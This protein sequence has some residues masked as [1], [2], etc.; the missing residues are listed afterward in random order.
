MTRDAI[1]ATLHAREAVRARH[2][3]PPWR[4]IMGAA[5]VYRHDDDNVDEGQLWRTVNHSLPSLIAAKEREL[6]RQSGSLTS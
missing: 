6:N 4:A 3:N 2:P 1:I 5:N